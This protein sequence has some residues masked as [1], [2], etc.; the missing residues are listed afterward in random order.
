LLPAKEI[1]I[2]LAQKSRDLI[3]ASLE[4][5]H[6]NSQRGLHRFAFAAR[7]KSLSYAKNAVK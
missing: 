3:S 5:N 2:W 7:A 1:L 6:T 4:D